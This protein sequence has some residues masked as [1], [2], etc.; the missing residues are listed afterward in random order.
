MYSRLVLVLSCLLGGGCSTVAVTKPLSATDK[1]PL[2]LNYC[3]ESTAR[4]NIIHKELNGEQ[5][6]TIFK[7]RITSAMN[8]VDEQFKSR[9]IQS[10]E[11]KINKRS[12]CTIPAP[13]VKDVNNLYLTIDI[14]GYGSIKAKWKRL[15]IGSGAVEA[16]AQGFIVGSLTQNPWFGIAAFTEEMTSEY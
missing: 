11:L 2:V 3:V 10:S 1:R 8:S 5:N 13:P 12:S 9:L 16:V 15:L 7:Q 4:M 14:S 6:K